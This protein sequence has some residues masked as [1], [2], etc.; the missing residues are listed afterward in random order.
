MCPTAPA[1]T[2]ASASPLP[3]NGAEIG[4][5]YVP[6]KIFARQ[7]GCCTET[8]RRMIRAGKLE[9]VTIDN[10]HFVKVDGQNAAS[11]AA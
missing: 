5:R 9:V 10:R 6:P 1:V 3:P 2:L 8:V 11:G 4:S 7:R